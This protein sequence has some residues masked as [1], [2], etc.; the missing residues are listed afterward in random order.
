MLTYYL[1]S[2]SSLPMYEQLYQGIKE[3]IIHKKILSHEKLPS[4]RNFAKHLKVS[5][6][7][8]ENAYH[9]LLIEGYIY[10]IEKK[11]LRCK[12][13]NIPYTEHSDTG[14][15]FIPFLKKTLNGEN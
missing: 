15:Y 10:S 12:L 13:Q 14:K 9:Q 11:G 4:K 5:I 2:H 7:T 1:D 6:I 3:D 8:I